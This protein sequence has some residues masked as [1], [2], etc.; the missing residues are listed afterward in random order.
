MVELEDGA[1]LVF[2]F[3]YYVIL[4]LFDSL[5]LLVP[6]PADE[7]E[8]Q[9]QFLQFEAKGS[10][11]SI[12]PVHHLLQRSL[13]L[14][15]GSEDHTLKC[16]YF[17]PLLLYPMRIGKMFISLAQEG[18]L[19]LEKTHLIAHSHRFGTHPM[20]LLLQGRVFLCDL[21]VIGL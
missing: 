5:Q 1:Y 16:L 8:L 12:D 6:F 3:D 4:G 21:D 20:E 14:C 19:I 10:V 2:Q 15:L 18:H 13:F 17:S 7:V 9:L 11:L